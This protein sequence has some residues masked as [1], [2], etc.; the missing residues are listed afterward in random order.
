MA[1][2]I[3]KQRHG[4]TPA[5]KNTPFSDLMVGLPNIL[6]DFINNFDRGRHPSLIRKER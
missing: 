5:E 3:L 6:T 1:A 2:A 4:V